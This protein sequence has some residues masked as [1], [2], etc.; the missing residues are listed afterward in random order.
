MSDYDKAIADRA[1]RFRE[2]V[3]P[4]LDDAYKFAYFLMRDRVRRRGCGSKM[5]SPRAALF[6]QL[7]RPGHQAVAARYSQERL[8]CGSRPARST[9]SGCASERRRS[10]R[11]VH[12]AASRRVAASVARNHCPARVQPHVLPRNSRS[13]RRFTG[14]CDVASG[15]GP[16]HDVCRT[17]QRATTRCRGKAA[18]SGS[19]NAMFP[20]DVLEPLMKPLLFVDIEF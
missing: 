8:P 15:A 11:N 5:L 14:R 7:A 12:S 4:C 13:D 9:Q 2:A 10:G 20:E 17:R 19:A 6:R 1:Q 3:L 16:G 18:R